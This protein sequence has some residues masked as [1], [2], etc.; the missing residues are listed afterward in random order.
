ML[1]KK[2]KRTMAITIKEI[3]KKSGFGVGTVSRALNDSPY[4]VKES[5]RKKI[6]N[7]ARKYGYTKDMTAQSLVTGKSKD[8]ALM[9]PAVFESMFYNDFYIKL[10]SS[11]MHAADSLGYRI[12]L[13][14]SKN[15]MQ[16]KE[17]LNWIKSFKIN[18][19]I[20]TP[21]LR[22]LYVAKEKV[23][24][25]GVPV[26]ILN[27]HIK[28]KNSYSV[29][30]DDFKGGYDGTDYLISLGHK[31]IA[32]IRGIQK[33]IE[34]R[35]RGYQRVLKENNIEID[36]DFIV[37]ADGT[38]P[39]AYKQI[40]KLLKKKKPSAI[41]ALDDEMAI[42][43]MRA[44]Y[45]TGLKCP[46]DISVLGFDGMDIGKLTI[47]QLSTMGRPVSEMAEKAVDLIVNGK[48]SKKQ[49]EYKVKAKLFECE[50]C[51]KPIM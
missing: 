3:A 22:D 5:T 27:E 6:L 47:P 4:L 17:I 16:F 28:G 40:R 33:D 51:A 34:Q 1:T 39:T 37:Q 50:S 10:I 24:E 26:V 46:Q 8:I 38:E 32:V 48:P 30:L 35:F 9:I 31:K 21:Y 29:S 36:K 25:F 11:S 23:R 7:I 19:V 45:E 14:L 44:M 41:F 18:G 42:G 2:G 20:L 12:R 15:D 43:A 13:L 49:R